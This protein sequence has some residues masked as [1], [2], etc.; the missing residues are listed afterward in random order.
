MYVGHGV[1]V[2]V[3]VLVGRGGSVGRGVGVLVGVHVAT[4]VSVGVTV[5]ACGVTRA[6]ACIVVITVQPIPPMTSK[7]SNASATMIT[8]CLWVK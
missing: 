8:F 3:G 5:G 1:G 4:G 6:C 2:K 7:S